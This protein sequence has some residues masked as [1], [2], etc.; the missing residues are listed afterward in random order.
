[1]IK[2]ICLRD[3]TIPLDKGF[4][5]FKEGQMYKYD[6]SGINKRFCPD[7]YHLYILN[8]KSPGC[9]WY[10]KGD[11]LRKNFMDFPKYLSILAEVDNLF[12]K[13]MDSI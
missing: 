10:V 12:I 9:G 5:T 1:M 6:I 4:R 3:C 13:N 11:F 2:I 8:A 7:L